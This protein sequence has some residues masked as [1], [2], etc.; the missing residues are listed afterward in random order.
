MIWAYILGVMTGAAALG[1]F[2]VIVRI[3]KE[4]LAPDPPPRPKDYEPLHLVDKTLERR[5]IE[6]EAGIRPPA[7]KRQEPWQSRLWYMTLPQAA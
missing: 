4:A 1:F 3:A 5:R 6:R 7:P 2:L